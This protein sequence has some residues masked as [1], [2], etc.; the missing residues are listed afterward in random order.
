MTLQDD[1]VMTLV[2]AFGGSWSAVGALGWWLSG[3]FRRVE[4][5]ATKALSAHEKLDEK[6]HVENLM[7]F[8]RVYVAMAARGMPVV[9]D[10]T[11]MI[12]PPKE[13]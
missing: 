7:N 6:R 8:G 12:D 11:T 4:I 10:G 13:G 3:Q 5:E 2:V 9:L 1:Q